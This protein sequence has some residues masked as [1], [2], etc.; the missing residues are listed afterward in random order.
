MQV[1]KAKESEKQDPELL[2]CSCAPKSRFPVL[3]VKNHENRR[4]KKQMLQSAD[5]E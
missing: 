2:Q 5:F 1:V 3:H 4:N